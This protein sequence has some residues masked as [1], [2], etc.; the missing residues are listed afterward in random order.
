MILPLIDPS[1]S[2]LLI[3]IIIILFGVALVL[4]LQQ[5]QYRKDTKTESFL[6]LNK[7]GRVM[8][9]NA[10]NKHIQRSAPSCGLRLPQMTMDKLCVDN[11]CLT[12]NDIDNFVNMSQVIHS[13]FEEVNNRLDTLNENKFS[14]L[15]QEIHSEF[16]DLHERLDMLSKNKRKGF[17]ALEAQLDEMKDERDTHFS[18]L[19]EKI[20]SKGNMVDTSGGDMVYEY[21][22]FRVH[23]F[24]K[25]GY[26][27]VKG[28][29]NVD[30]LIVGGGGG[31]GTY[32]GGGAGGVKFTSMTVRNGQ[33]VRVVVGKG[34]DGGGD[35]TSSNNGVR[36]SGTN[37]KN[38][39]NP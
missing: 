21:N 9:C 6:S 11:K 26:F 24:N 16:E 28:D 30:V 32:G 33:R 23:V 37:G 1:K 5:Q 20:A 19:K 12:A 4:A 35:E 2:I 8:D 13:K 15:S 29:K 34:G 18:K 3:I 31:G 7:T 17:S 22:G 36:G 14:D 27:A 39:K 38:S 25:T 10:M